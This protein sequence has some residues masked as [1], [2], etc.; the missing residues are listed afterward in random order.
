MSS[1]SL[2]FLQGSKVVFSGGDPLDSPKSYG[3]IR[4][5]PE[6]G[7]EIQIFTI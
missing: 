6:A 3:I 7:S 4:V 1:P 2:I 5:N